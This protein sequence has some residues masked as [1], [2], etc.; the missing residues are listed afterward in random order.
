MLIG[1]RSLLSQLLKIFKPRRWQNLEDNREALGTRLRWFSCFVKARENGGKFHTL[2]EE[3]MAELLPKNKARTAKI[4][5]DG[6]QLLFEKYLQDETSPYI[7]NLPRNRQMK[8]GTW[9]WIDWGK[10]VL[11]SFKDNNVLGVAHPQIGSSS[12]KFLVELE[13]RNVPGEKPLGAKERTN[14][15]LNIWLRRR[16]LNPGHIGGRRE[17]SPLRQPLQF[18]LCQIN[19]KTSTGFGFR[20]TLRIM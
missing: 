2:C 12:T 9:D 13:F 14:N 10:H 1:D 17:L 15:K 18:E 16:D 3:E 8:T 11:A 4:Q 5:L 7:L 6:F 20:M 19:N